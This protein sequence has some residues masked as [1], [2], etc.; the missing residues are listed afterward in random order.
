MLERSSVSPQ[1]NAD[2]SRVGEVLVEGLIQGHYLIAR[3]FIASADLTRRPSRGQLTRK[4]FHRVARGKRCL[5]GHPW[6]STPQ[7]LFAPAGRNRR[8]Q[9]KTADPSRVGDV[10]V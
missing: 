5:S 6:T 2:P 8:N 4:A 10:V 3:P 1:D 7:I 9:E